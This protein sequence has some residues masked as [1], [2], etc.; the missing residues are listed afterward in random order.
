MENNHEIDWL[1]IGDN[2][3]WKVEDPNIH[4]SFIHDA[5]N[6]FEFENFEVFL[7][8]NN[9]SILKERFISEMKNKVKKEI[10]ETII[11]TRNGLLFIAIKLVFSNTKNLKILDKKDYISLFQNGGKLEFLISSSKEEA[12]DFLYKSSGTLILLDNECT[13]KDYRKEYSEAGYMKYSNYEDKLNNHEVEIIEVD[14][15]DIEEI[16]II[17]DEEVE[18]ESCN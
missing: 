16:K 8:D 4:T 11:K 13:L 5:Y 14:E 3:N 17:Y 15:E 2:G 9:P 6:V 12:E 7:K 10:I 18:D 1:I